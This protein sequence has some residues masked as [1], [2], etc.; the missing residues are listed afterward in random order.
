MGNKILGKYFLYQESM[1]IKHTKT[2]ML[3]KVISEFNHFVKP[4]YVHKNNEKLQ[5]TVTPS[6]TVSV[7][8]LYPVY[9]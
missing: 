9:N 3:F 6:F 5:Y 2:I 1:E 4:I 8:T 7:V